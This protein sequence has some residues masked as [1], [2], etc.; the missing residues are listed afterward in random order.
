MM[1]RMGVEEEFLVVD[2]V[3]GHPVALGGMLQHLDDYPRVTGE[4]KQ[5]QIETCTLPRL[6]LSELAEDITAGRRNA[7]AVARRA[8][9]RAVALATSPLPIRPTLAPGERYGQL[10]EKFGVTAAEQLTC[11]CHVHVEISSDEEGVAVLDR[12]RTWLPVL[13]AIASNSPYW[14][15]ADSG[16]AGYRSQAWNRWPTTGPC[17]IFGSAAAYHAH[18]RSALASGVPLDKAA[19]YFDARLSD[20]HPTVEVRVAD[21]CLF[22]DDAVLVAALVRGL[23]ETAIREWRKGIPPL[24]VPGSV[25]RLAAWQASRYGLEGDLVDPVAGE[26][27]P[28][29]EMVMALLDHLRPVLTEQGELAA[30]EFLL[31]QV[32]S[33][34]TGAAVQRETFTAS[35][36]LTSTVLR[37]IETT[38]LPA[39]PVRDQGTPLI[40]TPAL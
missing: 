18:V 14:N 8:G 11:G 29:S 27:R 16:Y 5:E 6:T 30:V 17:D 3:R 36:N 35:G 28:A 13:Q 33:R 15:G 26:P 2:P 4:M 38:A 20:R 37:A 7:D 22:A 34:G 21:V 23:V 1:R 24:P 9:G 19:L 10:A 31:F 40:D 12:I 25:L 39:T 32:L